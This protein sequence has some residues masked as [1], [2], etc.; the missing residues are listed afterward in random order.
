MFLMM[1]GMRGM[2]GGKGSDSARDHD[3]V[4]HT[5]AAKPDGP[6]ERIDQP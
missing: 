2:S 5:D 3:A 6:H 4:K 1:R